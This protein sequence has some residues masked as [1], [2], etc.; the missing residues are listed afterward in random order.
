MYLLVAPQCQNRPLACNIITL[1]AANSLA[2]KLVWVGDGM[3]Y[4][5][6]TTTQH[7]SDVYLTEK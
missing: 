7:T 5:H 6:V 2:D 3:T 4:N 1:Q